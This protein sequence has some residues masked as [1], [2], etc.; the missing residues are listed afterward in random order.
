MHSKKGFTIIELMVVIAI[1]GLLASIVMVSL[2][3]AREKSRDSR[4]QADLKSIQLALSLYYNDN[5][6]YPKNIYA[7][8]G[9]APDNGLAPNYLPIVPVDPEHTGTCTNGNSTGCYRYIAYNYDSSSPGGTAICNS[10]TRIP[11]SYHLGAILE[12]SSNSALTQDV[13]AADGTGT[14]DYSDN[15]DGCTIIVGGTHTKFDGTSADC[16][17]T[18][19]TPQPNGTEACYDVAP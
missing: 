11:T 6:M 3:G 19:G 17:A 16:T 12:D 5:G 10:S 8:S 14:Y 2:G 13:D 7:T 18:A 9:S 15:Y 4:R 1:I